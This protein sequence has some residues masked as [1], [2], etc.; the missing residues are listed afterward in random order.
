MRRSAAELVIACWS[1][2]SSMWTGASGASR[3][4][5]FTNHD[6]SPHHP[7]DVFEYGRLELDVLR[8]GH[9]HVAVRGLESQPVC[10]PIHRGRFDVCLYFARPGRGRGGDR[11]LVA[12]L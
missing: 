5:Y 3:R 12:D 2:P 1:A 6:G 11:G 9:D 7:G 8:A 10:A 4:A